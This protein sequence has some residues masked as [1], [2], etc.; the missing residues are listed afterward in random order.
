MEHSAIAIPGP[1]VSLLVH[2]AHE[3]PTTGLLIGH[4]QDRVVLSVH[5][6]SMDQ[7]TTHEVTYEI[8]S[9]YSPPTPWYDALGDIAPGVLAN[10]LSSAQVPFT[11]RLLIS[12][13]EPQKRFKKGKGPGIAHHW[14]VLVPGRHVHAIAARKQAVDS[15]QRWRSGSRVQPDRLSVRVLADPVAHRRL[16]AGLVPGRVPAAAGRQAHRVPRPRRDPEHGA[17]ERAVG[18]T[19]HGVQCQR[20]GGARGCRRGSERGGNACCVPRVDGV[21]GVVGGVKRS[22]ERVACSLWSFASFQSMFF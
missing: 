7:H 8:T 14:P 1:L 9:I 11:S 5:D 10:V 15:A 17:V 16:C 22:G 2:E 21:G 12:R 13:F 6:H 20:R 4:V 18:S 3:N 19:Y